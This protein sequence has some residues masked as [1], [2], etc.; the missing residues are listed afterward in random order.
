MVSWGEENPGLVPSLLID[1]NITANSE[2]ETRP[3]LSLF[4]SN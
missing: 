3:I 4:H 2:G 1:L